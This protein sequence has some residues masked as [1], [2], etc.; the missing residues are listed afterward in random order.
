MDEHSDDREEDQREPASLARLTTDIVAAYVAYARVA[1]RDVADLIG[2]VA[3][4]L[5]K[6]GWPPEPEPAKL[7]PAVPVRRSLTPDHL[8]CLVC[9]KRQK[10]LKRHL[11][12]E[13][14]L[15]PGQ[16]RE[17]FGL[18]PDYPMTAPSYS[19]Q[20]SQTAKHSIGSGHLPGDPTTKKKSGYKHSRGSPLH[21]LLGDRKKSPSGP[22]GL[23]GGLKNLEG[24]PT[25]PYGAR[26]G[27][28]RGSS[29]KSRV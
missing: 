24:N 8:V 28:K 19:R 13:H 23:G 5:R 14:G 7:K 4:G 16:Y 3:N 1:S 17:L 25:T 9:G 21:V 29:S 15:T 18:K 6:V 2:A 10:M 11:A 20:R 12:A 27:R 22:Y 26:G